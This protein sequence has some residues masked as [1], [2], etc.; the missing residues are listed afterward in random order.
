[1]VWEIHP[2]KGLGELRFGQ[3]RKQVRASL[4]SDFSV[5]Q[6][7]EGENDSDSYD[8]LGLHLYYDDQDCLECIEAFEPMSP[9]IFGVS[10]VGGRM[11]EVVEKMKK[12]GH[13]PNKIDPGYEF[14]DLGLSFFGTPI[15]GVTIFRKGYYDVDDD[16]V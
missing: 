11:K 12:L 3:E 9:T 15:E 6:K 5:F 14:D 8:K 16:D 13:R 4:G 7:D 2:F 1:M 10:I